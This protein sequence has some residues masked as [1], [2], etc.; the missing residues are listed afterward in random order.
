MDTKI[1]RKFFFRSLIASGRNL[2]TNWYILHNFKGNKTK[3]GTIRSFGGFSSSSFFRYQS[4]LKLSS[5]T[6]SNVRFKCFNFSGVNRFSLNW[7][8]I[9]GQRCSRNISRL[10]AT[11][12]DE[13]SRYLITKKRMDHLCSRPSRT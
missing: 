6:I 13:I 11:F 12:F 8:S 3:V 4:P 7:L 9:N 2:H 1:F 5:E 10:L